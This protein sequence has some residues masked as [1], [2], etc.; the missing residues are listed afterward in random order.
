MASRKQYRGYL[1]RWVQFCSER[2]IDPVRA[3]IASALDFLSD[4]NNKHGLGYSALNTARS[5]LSSILFS[6][7]FVSFGSHPLVV[8]FMHGVY[9]S[10]PSLARYTEIWDVRIVLDKLKAMSPSSSLSLKDLTYKLVML[11]ALVSA[12]R[13]QTIHLL[14]IHNMT[15]SDSFFSFTIPELT[16]TSK[17]GDSAKV[18]KLMVFTPDTRLCVYDCLNE[19]IKRT[20]TLRS[21]DGQLFVSYVKPYKKVSRETIRRWLKHVMLLSGIDINLFKPH[22]TRAASTSA[23]TQA[24]Q[25]ISEILKVAGWKSDCTFAKFYNKPIRP[26]SDYANTILSI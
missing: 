6:T 26:T 10:R 21:D 15:I 5:A 7:E 20:D 2:K 1:K 11:V 14:N 22:S 3:P 23:A 17:P 12:Q 19:Y 8:R 25:P 13:G 24:E 9:N 18:I 4:L 16:K